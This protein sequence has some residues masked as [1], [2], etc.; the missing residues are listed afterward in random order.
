MRILTRKFS[1]V[2]NVFKTKDNFIIRSFY[3]SLV[4][5]SEWKK[6]KIS[7]TLYTARALFLL[8]N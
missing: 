5:K 8:S 1:T 7:V 6:N 4:M 2:I 3:P